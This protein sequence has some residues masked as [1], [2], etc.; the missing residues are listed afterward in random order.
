MRTGYINGVFFRCDAEAILVEDGMITKIGTN[1]EILA[2][3]GKDDGIVDLHGCFTVP[4]FVDSHMHLL[5]LGQF[6][7]NLQLDDCVSRAEIADL[8]RQ[9]L[10]SLKA[11][12]WIIGR[13]YNEDRFAD[14]AKPDRAMLDSLSRD[15]P[16]SL[17]RACGHAM[18]V[19]TKAMELAGITEQTTVEGGVVDYE[20][21]ILE[22]NALQL[23]HDAWPKDTPETIRRAI[24]AG[25]KY[26]NSKGITTVCSDDFPN[27][28]EDYRP[29]LDAL[30]QMSYQKSL[31]VRVNEQCEFRSV[32]EFA[33]FLD[34]GYTFD[35]GNDLFR[36]GPLKLIT[37]GSLGARTAALSK[38]YE[39]DPAKTGYMAMRDKDMELYTKLAFRYNMP[40]IA[41]CIGDEAVDRVL[42]AFEDTV[43]E[44][45]PLHHG[46]VHCQILRPDQI[47][48]ILDRKLVCY[49]QSLFIDYDASIVAA[50]VGKELA[51]TSYPFRTLY[52]G[53]IACNGSDAPV[54]LNDPLRGIQLAVTRRSLRFPGASMNEEEALTVTEAILSY[55][56]KGAEAIFMDDRIGK[57]AEGYYAD[58]AVLS[59]DITKCDVN[60][61]ADTDIL[62]TVMNGERVYEHVPHD[63]E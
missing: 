30:E 6:L 45:N 18:S 7:T 22:E 12:E 35:V 53:T 13:G 31:T 25:A 59:K 4:G 55:T 23:I 19:N 52:R 29:S 2:S 11:G 32:K 5:G 34:D 20:H 58:F 1:A 39:D 46:I 48:K 41:H 49:F 37:D 21:G 43:L 62:L 14:H 33:D 61:I 57:I 17:T 51:K 16:I 28:G 42:N 9:R 38:P 24:L 3:L 15:V 54:E 60:E 8:V 63:P 47:R 40:V 36:I 26:C 27:T 50:R 56:E 10:A 44:G